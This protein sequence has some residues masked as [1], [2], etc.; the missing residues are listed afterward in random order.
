ML[1]GMIAMDAIKVSVCIPVYNAESYIEQCAESLFNQTMKEGLEYVF[2]DDAS[3]DQSVARLMKVLER[4][5]LRKP[6]VKIVRCESN[7]GQALARQ[8]ALQSSS[9]QY[10]VF[11]DADDF[12]D[13]DLYEKMYRKAFSQKLDMVCCP[14]KSI[15]GSAISI[16]DTEGV[17][18]VDELIERCFY[19]C[20]FNSLFNKLFRRELLSLDNCF[21]PKSR[22]VCE[23]LIQ[24]SR[25][26][27]EIKTI[28]FVHDSYYNYVSNVNSVTN[29]I[30]TTEQQWREIFENLQGGAGGLIGYDNLILFKQMVHLQFLRHGGISANNYH[31]LWPEAQTIKCIIKSKRL[32]LCQMVL[33]IAAK[34]ALSPVMFLNKAR[35]SC[36]QSRMRRMMK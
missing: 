30:L 28:G 5:P 10:V 24:F 22:T 25:W 8:C 14:I 33:L 20:Y 11:C 15:L 4:Y 27:R 12:V 26:L 23:D 32:S 3:R 17:A 1:E 35:F 9:G 29:S 18:E 34:Y 19:S 13:D 16:H 36:Q 31:S 7:R 2:V 6:Y 21:L